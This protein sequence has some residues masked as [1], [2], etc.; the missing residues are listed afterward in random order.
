MRVPV[1]HPI[2]LNRH[3]RTVRKKKKGKK[4][5]WKRKKNDKKKE[6][7]ASKILCKKKSISFRLPYWKDYLLRYNLDMMH[8]EKM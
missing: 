3:R 2:P 7:A 8:I 1:R 6:P 4:K 5:K